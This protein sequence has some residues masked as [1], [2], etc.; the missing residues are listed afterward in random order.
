MMKKLLSISVSGL[1][2]VAILH[3][4][5]A[6]HYCGGEAEASVVS[7][8]GKLA[9]C[10]ME[11]DHAGLPSDHEL[12]K[13]HCCDNVVKTIGINSVYFPFSFEVQGADQPLVLIAAVTDI[14]LINNTT[15]IEQPSVAY[16]PPGQYISTAVSPE[17]ICVFRI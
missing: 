6:I 15:A 14:L 8:S 13:T 17:T 7:F 2:L 1:M 11:S 16:S 3:L 5:I 10:G 9:T 12:I 4:T